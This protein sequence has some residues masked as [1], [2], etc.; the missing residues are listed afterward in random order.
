M[1]R[2]R[3][4]ARDTVLGAVLT[5]GIV[6]FVLGQTIIG[7]VLALFSLWQ[8]TLLYRGKGGLLVDQRWADV[9]GKP[10]IRS[11]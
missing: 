6:A 3:I 4:L 7:L 8:F 9:E 2:M 11:K 10:R 5:G 1:K